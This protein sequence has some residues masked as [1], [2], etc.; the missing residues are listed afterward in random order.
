M[1][2]VTPPAGGAAH[3]CFAAEIPHTLLRVGLGKEGHL[4]P[5]RQFA[6]ALLDM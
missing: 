1:P 6:T 4:R 5:W 2:S 3:L